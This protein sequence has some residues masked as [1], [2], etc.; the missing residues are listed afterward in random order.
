MGLFFGQNKITESRPITANVKYGYLYNFYAVSN[1]LF[2]PEGWH[3]PTNA[4][5]YTLANTIDGF[6]YP[7]NAMKTTGTDYW[8]YTY[9]EVTNS[10]GMSL[11]GGGY[12]MNTDGYFG[13]LKSQSWFWADN[14]DSD[15]VWMVRIS[16]S[17]GKLGYYSTAWPKYQGASVILIKN[18]STLVDNLIDLDGNVYDVVKVGNQVFTV[19]NWACTKLNDGT[20]IPKVTD[21]DEWGYLETMALCAYDNDESNVFL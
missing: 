9:P 19:G 8:G 15:N 14:Y 20:P 6:I 18:N 13:Y 12:R 16:S 17:N 1:P 5:W 3:I 10:T 7:T 4:D 2:A 21:G 11:K